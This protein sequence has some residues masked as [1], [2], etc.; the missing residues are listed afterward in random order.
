MW[1]SVD[2]QAPGQEQCHCCNEP[3]VSLYVTAAKICVNHHSLCA[4]KLVLVFWSSSS[5]WR[6][7]VWQPCQ[8]LAL[9][10]VLL[11]WPLI[12]E[13]QLL[14]ILVIFQVQADEKD[15]YWTTSSLCDI[16]ACKQ[17]D[18]PPTYWLDQGTVF[19][20]ER[21]NL[22]QLINRGK[23]LTSQYITLWGKLSNTYPSPQLLSLYLVYPFRTRHI[24]S[25]DM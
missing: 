10:L 19:S 3:Y 13:H 18:F 8:W 6:P 16:L 21:E 5:G 11:G 17:C 12:V 9:L 15:K 25:I 7:C 22:T 23:A 24:C 20:R 2:H 14:G 4:M 1:M